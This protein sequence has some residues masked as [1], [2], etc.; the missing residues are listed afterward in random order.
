MLE[1]TPHII[2]CESAKKNSTDYIQ[3]LTNTL[4]HTAYVNTMSHSQ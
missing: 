1:S 4:A 3:P 2:H